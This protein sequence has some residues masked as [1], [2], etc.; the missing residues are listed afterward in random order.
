MASIKDK[1]RELYHYE[2]CGLTNVY[3]DGL[4]VVTDAHGEPTY[5]IKN[6]PGL[7]KCISKAITLKKSGLS[8]AEMRFLRTEMG[9]TQAELA[10]FIHKDSQ[11]IGRYEREETPIDPA[12]ATLVRALAVQKLKIGKGKHTS[13]EALSELSVASVKQD[14]WILIDG[15][16]PDN[17]KTKP[18][19][20]VA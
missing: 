2:E 19:R 18:Q 3:I 10:Q 9:M 11:T 13:V 16:D 8:G 1:N 17:Y 14:G 4:P 5:V 12:S 15:H 6:L 20:K 7:H